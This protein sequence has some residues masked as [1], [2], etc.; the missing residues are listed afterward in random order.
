[1]YYYRCKIHTIASVRPCTI[2]F[3]ESMIITP[4]EDNDLTAFK[5]A[6]GNNFFSKVILGD[7]A[8]TD[9]EYFDNKRRKNQNIELLTPTKGI[10]R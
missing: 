8:Y 7:K 9:K 1:M 5:Q 6:W 10:K 4:A 3:P 2:P